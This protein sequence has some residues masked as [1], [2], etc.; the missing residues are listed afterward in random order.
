MDMIHGHYLWIISSI[1]GCYSWIISMG[2]I[3]GFSMECVHGSNLW[4]IP[5]DNNHGWSLFSSHLVK[6]MIFFLHKK[7]ISSLH[8][9][10]I[11]FLRKRKIIFLLRFIRLSGYFTWTFTW[12]EQ[13]PTRRVQILFSA[14]MRLSQTWCCAFAHRSLMFYN[15]SLRRGST[16]LPP[17]L[18]GAHRKNTH[19]FDLGFADASMLSMRR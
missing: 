1:H 8:K 14:K 16:C 11:F 17:P 3:N 9:E 6:K 15:L 4:I 5:L 19:Q 13:L 12:T 10:R 2:T 18:H 7:K